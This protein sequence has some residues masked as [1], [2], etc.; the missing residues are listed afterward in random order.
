MLTI[1]RSRLWCAAALACLIAVPSLAQTVDRRTSFTFSGPVALP[2]VTLPAGSYLFRLADPGIS[3]RVVQVLSAD[4]TKPYA[5]FFSIRAERPQPATQPEVRF[6]ETA[7]GMPPAIK[8]WWYPGERIGYEFVY[9][10]DQARKLAVGASQPVLTT[11]AETTTVEQTNTSDL[12]RV[13]SSGQETTVNANAQPTASAP[14]GT[15]Q[16]GQIASSTIA[17]QSPSVPATPAATLAAN[18][19]SETP[20]AATSGTGAAAQKQARRSRLPQT[21]SPAPLVALVGTVALMT[22]AVLRRESKRRT[23]RR[24]IR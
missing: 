19:T 17:V 5:M 14:T 21:A 23:T 11:Q 13:S 3:N 20:Q 18:A 24:K 22:G 7:S 16:E 15:T 4:G 12:S 8:T 2:G 10:K 1:K 6:M 9:P